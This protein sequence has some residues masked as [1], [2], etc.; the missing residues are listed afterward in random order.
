MI[1]DSSAAVAVVVGEP[2]YERYKDQLREAAGKVHMSAVSVYEAAVVIR[3]KKGASAV[4][5]LWALIQAARIV[6]EPFGF[7]QARL[8]DQIYGHFG[9]GFSPIALNFGDCPVYALSMSHDFAPILSTSDEFERAA[10]D[11]RL[12][13]GGSAP[14]SDK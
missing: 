11:A 13:S 12:R 8:A 5:A 14:A 2:G 9:K 6:V 4:S 7:D 3:R 1:L 10:R